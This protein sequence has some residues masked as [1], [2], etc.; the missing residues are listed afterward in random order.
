VVRAAVVTVAVLVAAVAVVVG[1]GP[2]ARAEPVRT[3][4]AAAAPTTTT[5]V[6]EFRTGAVVRAHATTTTTT[7]K[8]R[9]VVL[10]APP[11]PTRSWTWDQLAACESSNRWD[12]VRGIYQGGLQFDARTWDHYAPAFGYPED[13]Q[14]A[15]REQQ[16]TV[17]ERVLAEQGARAWPTCGPR[18]GMTGDPSG[19]TPLPA[20]G[21]P[22]D[23]PD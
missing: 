18:I 16:I 12:V 7:V 1:L 22:D 6:P 10:P 14:L 19:A 3:V 2:W 13:A 17:A 23:A 20:A 11:T 8:V 5:S 4:T 21:E 15:T 9:P